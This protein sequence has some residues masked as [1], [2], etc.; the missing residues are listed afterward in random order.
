MAG[1]LGPDWA[2]R[3]SRARSARPS[4]GHLR[5]VGVVGERRAICRVS[6]ADADVL[7][8]DQQRAGEAGAEAYR[9]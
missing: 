4:G 2:T 9:W 7:G 5:D 8:D 6:A 3:C 1:S